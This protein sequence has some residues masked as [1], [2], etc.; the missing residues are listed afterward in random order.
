MKS[1]SV[2]FNMANKKNRCQLAQRLREG[3]RLRKMAFFLLRD[4]AL[5]QKSISGRE[6]CFWEEGVLPNTFKE[7]QI[8]LSN[9][10]Y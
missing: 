3:S 7:V 2:F 9:E 4:A 10:K 5:T 1:L 6:Y 8:Y